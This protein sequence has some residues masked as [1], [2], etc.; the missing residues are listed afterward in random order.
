[1]PK[2]LER[3]QLETTIT[4]AHS[5]SLSLAMRMVQD[6]FQG[7]LEK[8]LSDE[9][10]VSSMQNKIKEIW[11]VYR[12]G[13]RDL[14]Q[15]EQ[16]EG[17]LA[18]AACAKVLDEIAVHLSTNMKKSCYYPFSGVDFYWARIFDKVTFKDICFDQDELPN[19]W[20]DS[21]TYGSGRRQEIL[22]TL[23]TQGI[24][25]EQAILEFIVGNAEIPSTDNQFN[26]TAQTLLIK[27]GHD[28][29]GYVES[30]FGSERLTYRA[31]IT[32][33]AINPLRDIE[34]R[35][36]QDGYTRKASLEGTD[37]LIPYAMELRDIHIFLR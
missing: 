17:Y 28:F 19:M 4:R 36:T 9:L 18:T 12:Q 26:D 20:W 11:Q 5:D 35:L 32:V 24:I 3:V 1:M 14:E 7:D 27:G 22:A 6:E 30:R 23:K 15:L 2:S 8:A 34:K 29:L 31:I 13:Y 25:S 10:F 37:Y 21:E 16:K 33:A